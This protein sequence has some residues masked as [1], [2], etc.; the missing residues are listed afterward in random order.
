MAPRFHLLLL[1]QLGCTELTAPPTHGWRVP[2]SL[3]DAFDAAATDWCN[4]TEGAYCP[5][6][7]EQAEQA[8][9]DGSGQ[10]NAEGNCGWYIGA[11][12]HIWLHVASIAAGECP[13]FAPDAAAC[14]T[15]DAVHPPSQ[16]RDCWRV[17]TATEL[18]QGVI[19]HELG[20]AAG[21]AHLSDPLSLM[22]RPKWSI[23]VMRS[24][25][26]RREGL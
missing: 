17:A 11:D 14:G 5:Y 15:D 1:L 4:A 21:L 2:D 20:H 26:A 19:A 24:D 6:A 10:P 22:H 25:A 3:A 12:R 18:V 13:A 23:R 7:D 16:S 8:I 9:T